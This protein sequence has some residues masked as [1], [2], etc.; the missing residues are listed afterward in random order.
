MIIK[1]LSVFVENKSGKLAEV[2]ELIAKNGI[3]INALSIADTTD[4]GILRI[5]VDRVEESAALLRKNGM[6]VSV[7][8]II[9][10]DLDDKPGKLA[11]ALR[12][13]S[14]NGIFIEYVYAYSS[15]GKGGLARVVIR[16][17]DAEL[18]DKCLREAGFN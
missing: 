12:V 17:D 14:E 3:N 9:S 11:E 5:V 15:P 13:L 18:A 4:F 6:T 8:D 16:V 10:V 1:Q 2:T 7:C